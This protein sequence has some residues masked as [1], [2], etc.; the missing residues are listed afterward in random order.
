[1]A[2]TCSG[3]GTR[4]GTIF[5][6]DAFGLARRGLYC[7]RDLGLHAIKVKIFR[8][9]DAEIRSTGER[10]TLAQHCFHE[11]NDI[12]NSAGEWSHVVERDSERE[13]SFAADE[14]IG[15]LEADR[16]AER[17]R[18]ADRSAGVA[19]CSSENDA[20]GNRYSRAAAGATGNAV[21][22]MWIANRSVMRVRG[23]D[24]VGK[25]VH[26]EFAER[27]RAGFSRSPRPRQRRCPE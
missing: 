8:Q 19:A 14:A 4:M 3:S 20:R 1:M 18:D 5:A 2:M 13:T 24:P 9:A 22:V 25:F 10:K 12:V 16:S 27:D 21:G 7:L 26:V 15:G 11:K 17:S 6:P 23:G